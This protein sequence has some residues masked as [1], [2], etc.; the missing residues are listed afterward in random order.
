ML[1]RLKYLLTILTFASVAASA[2][3]R[4]ILANG[5]S[6]TGREI[7]V[8]PRF[9]FYVDN[10]AKL[11]RLPINEVFAV[12]I[13]ESPL[14]TIE[15]MFALE[16]PQQHS[17]ETHGSA[18]TPTTTSS[19]SEPTVVYK[20]AAA[21]NENL[22]AEY[23]APHDFRIGKIRKGKFKNAR[24]TFLAFTDSSTISNEDFS[25]ELKREITTRIYKDGELYAESPGWYIAFVAVQLTNKTDKTICIDCAS[26]MRINQDGSYRIFYDGK[27]YGQNTAKGSS[28]GLN[29]GA[30]TGALGI[31]GIVGTLAGGVNVGGE[32]SAGISIVHGNDR[33]LVIPPHAKATLPANIYPAKK[34]VFR[35]YEEIGLKDFAEACPQ[36]KVEEYA[37]IYLEENDSTRGPKFIISYYYEDD[38]MTQYRMQ[39]QLYAYEVF[40]GGYSDKIDGINSR[41]VIVIDSEDFLRGLKE[42]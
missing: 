19:A 37:P 25:M 1:R 14:Q 36:E 35:R 27:S 41:K 7:E 3:D 6:I 32:N 12:K 24:L 31:G 39:F 28:A 18:A 22:K 40:G 13:G 34:T 2:E 20:P 38:P 5:N 21:D 4:I 11:Q 9:V 30:V 8:S 16:A 23:K 33:F 17:E 42:L 29:L 15:S 26:T 10:N